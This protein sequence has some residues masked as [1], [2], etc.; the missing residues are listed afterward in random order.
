VPDAETWREGFSLA[1]RDL[2]VNRF[3]LYLMA[4]TARHYGFLERSLRT[5]RRLASLDLRR[6]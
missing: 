4:H 2:L 1:A 3:G 5:L 6:A